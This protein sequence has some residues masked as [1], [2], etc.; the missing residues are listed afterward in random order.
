M[1]SN[2]I[3]YFQTFFKQSSQAVILVDCE[4]MSILDLN[5]AAV[6]LYEIDS[7]ND[8]LGKSFFNIS[9]CDYQE[10]TSEKILLISQ[11]ILLIFLKVDL[12]QCSFK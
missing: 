12:I 5:S 8:V 4:L 6:S 3:K 1:N 10:Y 9:K 2:I 11:Q 7:K